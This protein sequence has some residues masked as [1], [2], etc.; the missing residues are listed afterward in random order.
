[1]QGLIVVTWERYLY[2]RFG[3]EFLEV[4]RKAIGL[5]SHTVPLASRIYKDEQWLIGV[6]AA[7]KLT[8]LSPDTLLREYG[9]YF[10]LNGLTGHFCA[11]LL[12][13]VRSGR[14]LLLAMRDAHAQMRRASPQLIPP[15]FRYES[16]SSNPNELLLIYDSPRHLCSLLWG[17]IEGAAE[18]YGEA[19]RI[20]EVACMKHG[21]PE[22]RLEVQFLSGKGQPAE[23]P[24]QTTQR[25]ARLRLAH[26]VLLA[27]PER[28][29]ITLPEL[30]DRL[31][32]RQ[33]ETEQ[34]R[35][36]FLLE[37]LEHLQFAGLV[38]SNAGQGKELFRRRYWRAPTS[39]K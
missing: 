24:A 29:G 6:E 17:T 32:Q 23:T 22:C 35:P 30:A 28:E 14:A 37:A 2:E 9:R 39:G 13:Q 19:V 20:I 15:I 10:L 12:S 3:K 25:L 16:I 4:Y 5:Q 27:L 7:S 31:R 36:S 21:A 1:M 18:R 38:Q 26:L 8:K 11:Y 33:V 34:L